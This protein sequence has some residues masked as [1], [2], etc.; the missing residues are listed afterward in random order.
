MYESH[1]TKCIP[2]YDIFVAYI[3]HVVYNKMKTTL[4]IM[5]QT[6]GNTRRSYQVTTK[7]LKAMYYKIVDDN[8]LTTINITCI[9]DFAT[10]KIVTLVIQHGR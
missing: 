6:K 2:M 3:M 4:L 1:L 9:I 10:F 7:K 5:M 8:N